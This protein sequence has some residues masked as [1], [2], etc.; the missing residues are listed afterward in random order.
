[1][2]GNYYFEHKKKPNTFKNDGYLRNSTLILLGFASAF[3]PRL[4][5]T[6]GAPSPINFAHFAIIPVAC[7]M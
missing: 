7:L 2:M 1:M 3:F 5:T 4:L 6:L